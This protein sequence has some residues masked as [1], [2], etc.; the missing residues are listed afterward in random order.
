M[1]AAD[2]SSRLGAPTGADDRI[3]TAFSTIRARG[4]EILNIH[5]TLCHSPAMLRAQSSYAT[6]LRGESSIPR[7]MQQLAILRVCQ[8]NDGA[9]EWNVHSRVAINM[10]LP[11]FKI[12]ALDDW[13]DSEQFSDEEKVMLAFVDKAS[14]GNGIDD[15]VFQAA[16][17]AFGAVG[18]V[19]LASLVAW[20]VGNTRF[21]KALEIT[22]D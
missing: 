2:K 21:T 16:K 5:R 1:N 19:D 7:P 8:L 10:G 22:L 12:D 6:A 11:A 3:T 18:V 20:Y 9:Y 4:G 15:A 13:S 14:A 17:D